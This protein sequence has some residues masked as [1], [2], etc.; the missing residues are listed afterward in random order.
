MIRPTMVLALLAAA[1]PAYAQRPAGA[2]LYERYLEALGGKAAIRKVTARHVW[3]RFEVPA[4]GM[5]GP[6]EV[7]TAAPARML[8]RSEIPGFGASQSGFD[9]ETGWMLN[10]AMGP[11]L[12]DGVALQ[13]LRQQSDMEA[14]TQPER[15][16]K[17][18]E[19][20][21]EAEYGGKPC[22]VVT[23]TTTWGEKYSECYDKGSRLLS[24]TVRKQ[25][26]PMG[27][28][29]ATTI[30]ADYKPFGGPVLMSSLVR[31]SAMGIEQVIRI[32]SVS[33]KPIPDS[34]FALPKE[35]KALKKP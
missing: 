6:M 35:V 23:V 8:T 34:A 18:R 28:I 22:W 13:Q 3:G 33:T 9:G 4:Q 11:M 21:G 25:N 17:S 29:E 31:S 27:E 19:T 14:V 20:T 32:D 7:L 2:E 16:V 10:A 15:Y 1:V 30:Y 24:A 12:I 5:T 26:T